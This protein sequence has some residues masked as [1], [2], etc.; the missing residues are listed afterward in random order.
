MGECYSG[1]CHRFSDMNWKMRE[2]RKVGRGRSQRPW[3]K[4]GP[5]ATAEQEVPPEHHQILPF[6]HNVKPDDPTKNVIC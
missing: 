1:G 3:H 2:G 4:E 6:Q 5:S